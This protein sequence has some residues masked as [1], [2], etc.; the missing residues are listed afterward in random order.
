MRLSRFEIIEF[1]AS[2]A[3]SAASSMATT[4]PLVAIPR[5]LASACERST[6]LSF[7]I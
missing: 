3:L 6:V 1:H 4:M 2:T 5:E 7:E